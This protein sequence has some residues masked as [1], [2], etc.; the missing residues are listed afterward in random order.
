MFQLNVSDLNEF[1]TLGR[2]LTI[3]TVSCFCEWRNF[4]LISLP[5]QGY[6]GSLRATVKFA[7]HLP[8]YPQYKNSSV[9]FKRYTLWSTLNIQRCSLRHIALHDVSRTTKRIG[10]SIMM[11]EE[12]IVSTVIFATKWT[13]V[14]IVRWNTQQ[15]HCRA[16]NTSV[17]LKMVLN[18]SIVTGNTSNLCGP[19]V[20]VNNPRCW[21]ECSFRFTSAQIPVSP[22]LVFSRRIVLHRA[23]LKALI[24]M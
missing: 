23:I 18:H 24:N 3:Y 1:Y 2:E 14:I 5:F 13:K 12:A 21:L 11:S 16:Y 19:S 22:F 20:L 9:F 7:L 10:N 15:P 8:V 6:I 4:D 17:A